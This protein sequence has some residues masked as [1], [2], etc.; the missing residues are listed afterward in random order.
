MISPLSHRLRFPWERPRVGHK[1]R[2]H[3]E[4]LAMSIPHNSHP[5]GLPA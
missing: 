3:A 2:A 5:L 1:T 4:L